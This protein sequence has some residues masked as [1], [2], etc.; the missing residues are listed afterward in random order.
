MPGRRRG[1]P[2]AGCPFAHRLSMALQTTL[3]L[4][5][6]QLLQAHIGGE[7]LALWLKKA[8]WHC[9]SLECNEWFR[10]AEPSGHSPIPLLHTWRTLPALLLNGIFGSQCYIWIHSPSKLL[11]RCPGTLNLPYYV[12]F[13]LLNPNL[14]RF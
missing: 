5:P 11:H 1:W 3:T 12:F 10:V 8:P 4:L 14:H 7:C 2:T 9:C 6:L 13:A